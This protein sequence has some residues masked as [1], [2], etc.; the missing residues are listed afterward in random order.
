M[1]SNPHVPL[2]LSSKN[3]YITRTYL[4][5]VEDLCWSYQT[6]MCFSHNP[7]DLSQKVSESCLIIF[8]ING[9]LIWKEL[10]SFVFSVKSHNSASTKTCHQTYIQ[11]ML[12]TVHFSNL[13]TAC[14]SPIWLPLDNCLETI[15]QPY[16]I[17]Q[18]LGDH[19][20]RALELEGK[21]IGKNQKYKI[22]KINS[23][24]INS[25]ID[26][27]LEAHKVHTV[28]YQSQRTWKVKIST[29]IELEEAKRK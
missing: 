29:E 25:I 27:H 19:S 8:S 13:P 10:K 11:H 12:S 23:I 24:H 16:V 28:Q 22:W 3:W 15:R 1:L 17:W 7:L 5:L 21:A 4:L 9:G 20:S 14:Q 26:N 2:S 18:R 6:L